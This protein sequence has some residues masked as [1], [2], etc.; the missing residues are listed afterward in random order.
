M[1]HFCKYVI[2]SLFIFTAINL[3]GQAADPSPQD[4]WNHVTFD[5]NTKFQGGKLLISPDD[6]AWKSSA[7][8]GRDPLFFWN[9][10][11][12]SLSMTIA[13]NSSAPLANDKHDTTVF[14]GL[15]TDG[16]A[17]SIHIQSADNV[18]G[19]YLR[20]DRKKNTI[21]SA[22]GRKERAGEREEA[23][24]D[25]WGNVPSVTPPSELPVAS[26]KV[27]ISLKIDEKAFGAMIKGTDSSQS[28]PISELTR[29]IWDRPVFLIVQCQNTATGR[30]NIAV[31][32]VSLEYP[33][34]NPG[35][36]QCLDLR[37]F[38][39]MGFKD[40]TDGDKQGGWTDQGTNDM[41]NI[42]TGMQMLKTIPFDIIN[43]DTN[44]GKSCVMLY[45]TKKDF[46]SK[47]VGP[48]PVGKKADSIIFLHAAAWAGKEGI[49]AMRYRIT[50]D[51]GK[52]LE[53]PVITGKHLNDWW[54]LQ[55][56][57]DPNACLIMD[58]KSENSAR[59]IVGVY[60]LRWINPSP[61]KS[62]RSV[63]FIS[64]GND[65]VP[66]I[67]AVT[68]VSDDIGDIGKKMIASAFEKDTAGDIRKNPP[69]KDQ[70]P[71]HIVVKHEKT[72][73]KN[74]FSAAGSY[75]G[76]RGGVESMDLPG[77]APEVN[78]IGGILRY[79]HGFEGSFSFWPYGINDWHPTLCA[80][81]GTY[82][83]I[84]KWIYKGKDKPAP[85]VIKMQEMLE[86]CRKNG[87]KLIIQLNCVSMFDGKD[88]LYMKTLPEDRMKR[89]NPLEAG[90]F[91]QENLDKIVANNATMV[92]YVI[93]KGYKDTVA[94][95]EMD[96]E[97]WDMPGSDYAATVA[98]HVKMIRSKIPEA[99]MIVCLAGIDAYCANL[100]GSR[101]I[102]WNKELLSALSKMGMQSE[103]DYFA[104]HEYPF[105]HDNAEEITQN[106]L[107]DW[108]IRN[109]YRDLDI[110]SS[111]LDKYGFNK[112]KLYISEW[113]VQSD[114]L[115]D[116]SR[117]DLITSMASGLAAA[118]TIM[119][120][121]S[122]PRVEGGTLHPYMHASYIS[123]EK[124]I[125]ASKWG[126]QSLFFT[127]DGKFISTPH[128]EAVK[129][130]KGFADGSTLVPAD[131]ALPEGIQC[132]S[133]TD[134]EGKKYFAVNSTGKPFVFPAK[135]ISKRTSLFSKSVIDTA[136]KYGSYCD[137]PEEVKEIHPTAFTDNVLPPFSISILK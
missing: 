92:D 51:D 7:V 23:R 134:K 18:L 78:S 108:C 137:K 107:E 129:M 57:A 26:G 98:A 35:K 24:G 85:Y 13:F 33:R 84:I 22:L 132:L 109:L 101:Y 93:S 96:N 10:K 59:G 1:I 16:N 58:V 9:E 63:S 49:E 50:Y 11:G 131:L 88:F 115:G 97:R 69:D 48:I 70:I 91:S 111:M 110:A 29:K 15:T 2:L 81:G 94:F 83:A 80:K 119:A 60:A 46:F 5:K 122:H 14:V 95:W 116:E 61:E 104:P 77:F 6:N 66:G 76:G 126:C 65:P 45:S 19:I 31:D 130:F 44:N 103:I 133:A 38:A 62:V 34:L 113:G 89:E 82:G 47:E 53:I 125:R 3:P 75:S 73:G 72:I 54:S 17:R 123:K 20:W 32:D 21:E 102:I 55:E 30:A 90:T 64:G 43:P 37:P 114:R 124:G 56:P 74:G 121:Y 36:M 68:L 79:P 41:R 135:D 8:A 128:L 40:E 39:N 4:I 120:L 100:D 118:K 67:V 112:S 27:S 117:N 86:A 105:L 42:P 12:V 106:Y 87:L 52:E 25:Q 28:I 99:K 136:V 127:S 71:A